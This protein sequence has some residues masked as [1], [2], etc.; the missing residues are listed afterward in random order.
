MKIYNLAVKLWTVFFLSIL[1][2]PSLA[3]NYG[4]GDGFNP[5]NPGN[6]GS[7][8]WNAATGEVIV[9]DFTPGS[10]DSTIKKLI[11]NSGSDAVVSIIVSGEINATDF[12]VGNNYKNCTTVDFSRTAGIT[13]VP[14]S[15]YY[16]NK[17]LTSIT[18]PTSISEIESYAFYG[19]TA[20]TSLTCYSFSPPSVSSSALSRLSD[21]F[22]VYVPSHAIP[23]YQEADVWKDFLILPIQ[24]NVHS[25]T[26]NMPDGVDVE[27]Y[28]NMNLEV[29]NIKSG[30]T[31]KYLLTD[32][33]SYV[34][35]YMVEN[36]AYNVYVKND[37]NTIFAKIDSVAINDTDVSVTFDFVSVPQTV[38]V[39]VMAGGEDVT[40]QTTITWTD[41]SG[42]YI[43]QG[44]SL[45]TLAVGTEIEYSIALSKELSM[46]YKPYAKGYYTVEDGGNSITCQLKKIE[47]VTLEGKVSDSAT[48]MPLRNAF[49][50]ASQIFGGKY[51]STLSAKTDDQGCYK[52]TV[53][54]V[55]T[56]VAVASTGYISQT[57]T[58]QMPVSGSGSVVMPDVTLKPIT[59]AVI[60]LSLT[61]TECPADTDSDGNFQEW[62]SDYNN[63]SYTI[64]NKTKQRSISQ[65]NVQYPQIVLLED[66][67]DGDVLEL[68]ATSRTSSFMPVHATATID[69]EQRANALFDIVELG[70]IQASFANNANTAVVGT[71]YD[72]KGKYVKSYDY[73]N[74]SLTISGLPD[75]TYTLVSMGGSRFFNTIYD[76]SSLSQTGLAMGT[77]YVQNTVEV[78]SGTI[79]VVNIG[80]I[81]A[82]DES[83][84]YYTGDNTSFTVNKSSIVVGNYLTLTGH[85]DFKS[86][87]SSK[88]SNVNLI[89]DLPESCSFVEN[90]VMVGNSTS[91]YT[92]EGNRVIIPVANYTDRV[93]FC[94]I[95]TVGGEYSPS[96][97]VQFGVD[98]ETVTQPIG[99]ANYTAENLSIKVPSLVAKT[100]IPVSGTAIGASDIEIYDNDVLIGRTTS[101]ANGTW[102]TMCE[103]NE[104]SDLSRHQIYA[105]VLT[106]ANM[107]LYSESVECHI[108][109]NAIEVKNVNMSFYNAWM[110]KTI[111]VNFDM[112]NGITDTKAYSFYT[113]TDFTFLVDFSNNDTTLVRNVILYVF[114]DDNK[115]IPLYPVYNAAKDKYIAVKKFSSSSLPKN[116]SVGFFQLNNPLISNK[117]QMNCQV[118]D[119]T[120]IKD[121]LFRFAEE[122]LVMDIV[123]DNETSC[124]Y[125]L[126]C[127][128]FENPQYLKIIQLDYD[129][130]KLLLRKYSFEHIVSEGGNGYSCR[131]FIKEDKDF[132]LYLID[133]EEQIS[134]E[135]RLIGVGSVSNLSKATG[136]KKLWKKTLGDLRREFKNP[137]AWVG[138]GL[139]SW[140]FV[141]DVLGISR[142]LRCKDFYLCC[143]VMET[144]MDGLIAHSEIVSKMILQKCN[145]GTYR[146]TD[147]QLK[148]YSNELQNMDYLLG[149]YFSTFNSYVDTYK[150]KLISSL[151]TDI[152]TMGISNRLEKI[153]QAGKLIRNKKNSKYFQYLLSNKYHRGWL[154]SGIGIAFSNA[155]DGLDLLINPEFTQFETVESDMYKWMHEKSTE[156]HNMYNNMSERIVLDQK[157]CSTKDN[158]PTPPQPPTADVENIKDPSG[159]VYEGVFTNRVEGV[160]ATCYYKQI[161]EDMYGDKHEDIVKWDASEYAQENPL[162][163]DANGFFRWDVPNGLWQVKFEKEGYETTYSEWL[164]VPP[165]QLDVNIAMTQNVQPN[166]KNARAYEDAVEV[167]FDKYMLPE[168]LTTGNIIV[169]VNGM[170]VEG[171]IE[172]LNEETS[173]EGSDKTFASKVR[174]NANSK[175]GGSEVMLIVKNR[176][177]SYAGLRMEDDFTQTFTIEPEI[178]KIESDPSVMIVYG[179]RDQIT[180]CVTPAV[181]A[182]GKVLTAKSSSTMILSVDNDR[183]VIGADGK[184]TFN[185]N[186]ELPGTAAVTFSIEG[187]DVTSTT[188][189]NVE[190]MSNVTTATPRASIASGSTVNSGTVVYL[191]CDTDGATIYYTL[192]GSCP[193]D[194]TSSR[195]VY[196]GTPITVNESLTIRAMAV[197]PNKYDSDVV[198]FS[199]F[200]GTGAGVETVTDNHHLVITPIPVRDKINITAGDDIIKKVEI[201]AVNG[202]VVLSKR[203]EEQSVSL[204]VGTLSPGVYVVKVVTMNGKYIRKVIKTN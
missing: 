168:L 182:V 146:L 118:E 26:V 167:E 51:S 86:A 76:L 12:R 33:R 197:S 22:V 37:K 200:V 204:N 145:D 100:T 77:D 134:F 171:E 138:L 152:L 38:E 56:T 123:E 18:L 101:L 34:F 19:C 111:S 180:V 67:E 190:F 13:S 195:M 121:S 188:V 153:A 112:Q 95:P 62:Y 91:M 148:K 185:V 130:A 45:K 178:Q 81:P 21:N 199:Y 48:G 117:E 155:I 187:Y 4:I 16:G 113:A 116:V 162:F 120:I 5:V 82:L 80:E 198:E 3:Q 147:A 173:Y 196:D 85:I 40:S 104:P 103:L 126:S 131:Y 58:C 159:F 70:K 60:T 29:V 179:E 108:S 107:E 125:M 44:A 170:K 35:D 140:D 72:D 105:K 124:T 161:I 97:F 186:G 151:W 31:Y 98:G 6:P 175:F 55:P 109:L 30:Q 78:K 119:L 39:M 174:F 47:K 194:E 20:L 46:V 181:A 127:E 176:V 74:A 59:G 139:E 28:K 144:Y 2:S 42:N 9:D 65:F 150:S 201:Q 66:V 87:Y 158:P 24:E 122:Q 132:I 133:T 149:S 1:T 71:L 92:I 88:V 166:V 17:H 32:K 192:D 10:L 52:L 53:S 68:T 61:Y 160:K 23:L 43:S 90:S 135:I 114:T 163:T 89:V 202:S 172:L 110:K 184:A 73:R 49:V 141:L 8:G 102:T 106:K 54:N 165:P 203:F 84:L 7:N 69:A 41:S 164:P 183:I 79:S 189:V 191:S 115:V 14:Q 94:I 64:F 63:I 177:K 57:L 50:S 83:K 169:M 99:S 25:L 93:R 75:G 154:E 128:Y 27:A 193:C 137:K 15:A 96:A 11:G 143:D 157:S 156:Y 129:E 136:L 36:T 142:Y